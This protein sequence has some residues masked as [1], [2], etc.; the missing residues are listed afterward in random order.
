MKNKTDKEMEVLGDNTLAQAGKDSLDNE[1]WVF[2]DFDRELHQRCPMKLEM[3]IFALCLKGSVTVHVNLADYT[4]TPN[5]L[6]TLMPDHILQGLSADVED[7]KGIFLGISNKYVDEVLPDIHTILPVVFD[8]RSTPIIQLS[9]EDSQCLQEFHAMLW[10]LVRNEKGKYRKFIV[11]N[12][13]RAML[14]K[15]LDIYNAQNNY[16]VIKRSRNEEIFYNFAH[17]VERDHKS[18]RSVQHYADQLF[19]TPKHLT[20][21]VKTVSG[22]T[23]S[24]WINGYVILAA[25]VMLRTSAKTILEISNDL[26]FPN[27][28]FFGKYFKQHTGVSPQNY[29]ISTNE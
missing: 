17:L 7:A 25:K 1:V 23:A 24:D 14:Y 2:D 8:F 4:I 27:Q 19:I 29:R 22:Q 26:N 13:L 18:E 15:L 21:V 10:K 20:T 5:C 28:S 9:D 16:A 3:P 11:Q 6:L 12:Y